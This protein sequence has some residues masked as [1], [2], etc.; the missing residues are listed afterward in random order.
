MKFGQGID[1]RILIGRYNY[2]RYLLDKELSMTPQ[3]SKTD[4]HLLDEYAILELVR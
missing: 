2:S 3:F 1:W 4:Y